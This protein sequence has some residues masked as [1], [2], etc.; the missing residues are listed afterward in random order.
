MSLNEGRPTHLLFYAMPAY[1]PSCT[2]A[3]R[4][5]HQLDLR[6]KTVTAETDRFTLKGTGEFVGRCPRCAIQILAIE[7]EI[8]IHC[9][10]LNCRKCGEPDTLKVSVRKLTTEAN[11]FEFEALLECGR[12]QRKSRL[13]KILKRLS[14]ILSIEIGLTGITLKAQSKKGSDK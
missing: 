2:Q 1:C 8:P 11:A 3:I 14:E 5:D 4:T 10:G 7:N 13:T 9:A 6:I 12:C